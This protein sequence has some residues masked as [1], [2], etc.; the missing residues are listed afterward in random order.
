MGRRTEA[1]RVYAATTQGFRRRQIW[2]VIIIAAAI[3][4][5]AA[6]I[7]GLMLLT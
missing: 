2:A 4:W 3:G 6:C 7:L 5:T 1:F